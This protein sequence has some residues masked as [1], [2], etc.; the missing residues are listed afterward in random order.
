MTV[1]ITPNPQNTKTTDQKNC[2][3]LNKLTSPPAYNLPNPF[4]DD[5][6]PSNTSGL[7]TNPRLAIINS[8]QSLNN[9]VETGFGLYNESSFN[10]WGPYAQHISANGET[11]GVDFP[12]RGTQFGTIHTHPYNFTNKKWIPMFSLD[13]IYSVLQIRNL[14]T[15]NTFLNNSTN[16]P[17]GDSLFVSVFIAEQNGTAQTYA[18]KIDDITKFQNLQAIKNNPKKWKDLDKELLG[19]YIDD[20]N[21]HLGTELQYQR[22][23]L[24]FIRDNDLGVSLYKMEQ[25][26]AGTSQVQE[27]WTKL[28][29]GLGDN[30]NPSQC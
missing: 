15:T 8:D 7:N 14:Y 9:T 20:A 22:V 12:P 11:H 25:T 10:Q 4:L 6:H 28:E 2:E 23:L 17:N 1:I 29:L 3:E 19:K 30:V 24:N 13:D 27:T 16:N 21:D 5:N 26:N 18:I